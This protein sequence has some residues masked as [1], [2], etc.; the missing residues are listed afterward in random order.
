MRYVSSNPAYTQSFIF[1]QRA[2]TSGS[3]ASHFTSISRASF[4]RGDAASASSFVMPFSISS[5]TSAL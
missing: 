1:F 4:I 5:F 2:R 3:P